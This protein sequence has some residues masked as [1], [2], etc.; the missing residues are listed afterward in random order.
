MTNWSK[1]SKDVTE[2]NKGTFGFILTS[3]LENIVTD[4]GDYLVFME[5][6]DKSATNYSNISKNITNYSKGSKN[7]TAFVKATKNN[8]EYADVSKK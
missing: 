8:T 5:M 1:Q 3:D 6:L 2:F 4:S 7:Q